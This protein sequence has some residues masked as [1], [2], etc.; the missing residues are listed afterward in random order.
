MHRGILIIPSIA[1]GL[2]RSVS[3]LELCLLAFLCLSMN[4]LRLSTRDL[5]FGIALG[6]GLMSANDFVFS[7][8][9]SAHTSLTA[10]MQL[11]T[12]PW[13]WSRSLFGERT[14]PCPS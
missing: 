2:M 3:V 9:I 5:A 10:P 7:S 11:R 13:C 4:A 1:D 14:L 8:L 6:F 12:S